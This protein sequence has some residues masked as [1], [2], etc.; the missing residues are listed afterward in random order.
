MTF[1]DL[2]PSPIGNKELFIFNV[3]F[4]ISRSGHPFLR[5]DVGVSENGSNMMVRQMRLS[6]GVIRPPQVRVGRKK[7][8][9]ALFGAHLSTR[10]AHLVRYY[11]ESMG[12][13]LELKSDKMMTS[14]MKMRENKLRNPFGNEESEDE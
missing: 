1:F 10:I 2:V 4:L 3:E 13:P 14:R 8:D 11:V 5:F 7:V 9:Q 12:F 6:G